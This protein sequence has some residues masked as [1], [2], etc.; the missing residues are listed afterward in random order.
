MSKSHN[1]PNC[2]EHE[3]CPGDVRDT[4]TAYPHMGRE[5]W[6]ITGTKC[7]QGRYEKAALSEKITYCIN[8]CSYYQ[9]YCNG[10]H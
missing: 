3:M 5:C 6:K 2:W 8:S 1:P 4:C 10:R 9:T 7:A